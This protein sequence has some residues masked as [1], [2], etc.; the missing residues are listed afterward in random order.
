LV[1]FSFSS[2]PV[3]KYYNIHAGFIFFYLEDGLEGG[4]SY[5]WAREE[6][7]SADMLSVPVTGELILEISPLRTFPKVKNKKATHWEKPRPVFVPYMKFFAG[8][9]YLWV[10][11]EEK[12]GYYRGYSRSV[13][14]VD[15][16]GGAAW[17]LNMLWFPVFP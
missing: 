8:G 15:F 2:N 1:F 17:V 4:A 12:K 11:R 9:S 7:Y 14:S 3:S 6:D 13:N 16:L 10:Q 5:Y